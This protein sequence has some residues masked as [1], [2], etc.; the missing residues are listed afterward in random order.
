M[1]I[2]VSAGAILYEA[3]FGKAPFA[4]DSLL[5]LMN[6]IRNE[7]IFWPSKISD[8]PDCTAFLQGLLEK[9]PKKRMIWS[10]IYEHLYLSNSPRIIECKKAGK[11]FTMPLTGNFVF[12][13]N[14]F[15]YSCVPMKQA[16]HI[17]R[18][19]RNFLPNLRNEEALLSEQV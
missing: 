11:G 8:Q 19:E 2:F 1:F 3:T 16:G 15:R 5:T 12:T 18:A 6:K 13:S 17:K 10:D 14:V 7:K 4:T 9:D